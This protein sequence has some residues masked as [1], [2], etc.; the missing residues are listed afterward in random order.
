MCQAQ[1]GLYA[2]EPSLRRIDKFPVAFSKRENE[3]V[4]MMAIFEIFYISVV[5]TPSIGC[6]DLNLP[7]AFRRM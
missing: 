4:F 6:W 1:L 3:E 2:I 5:R 7:I